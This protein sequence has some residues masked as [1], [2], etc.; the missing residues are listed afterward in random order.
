MEDDTLSGDQKSQRLFGRP[1][2]YI[3]H[4]QYFCMEGKDE[5]TDYLRE[6]KYLTK[7]ALQLNHLT[8]RLHAIG[9]TGR[10]NAGSSIRGNITVC[11]VFY[12]SHDEFT[13]DGSWEEYVSTA[14]QGYY[15]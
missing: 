13:L 3:S 12:T 5:I 6:H 1:E 9:D 8:D 10:R 4:L 14:R 2:D 11:T 7:Q 15:W